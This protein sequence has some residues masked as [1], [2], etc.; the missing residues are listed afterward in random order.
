MLKD[1]TEQD[2]LKLKKKI[3]DA[4]SSVSELKGQQ[5]ATAKQLKDEFKCDTV[6]AGQEKLK[7]IDDKIDTINSKLDKGLKELEEEYR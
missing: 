1:M 4:K 7:E 2:L 3:E 5:T 6:E